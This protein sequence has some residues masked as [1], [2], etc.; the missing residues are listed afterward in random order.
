MTPKKVGPLYLL[1]PLLITSGSELTLFT[2]PLLIATGHYYELLYSELLC[3][4]LFYSVLF[5]SELLY[6]ELLYSELL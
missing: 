5:Y 1:Y 3:S 6:S 4:E 2:F